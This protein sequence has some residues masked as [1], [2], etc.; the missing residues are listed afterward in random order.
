MLVCNAI[1]YTALTHMKQVNIFLYL[2][3][4]FESVHHLILDYY[5]YPND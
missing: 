3:S 2:H 1:E 5:F 4:H